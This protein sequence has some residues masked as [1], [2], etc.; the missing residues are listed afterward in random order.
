MKKVEYQGRKKRSTTNA[1]YLVD[2]QGLPLAMSEP[3]GGKH[4]DL[5]E[6]SDR[7]DEI[8]EQLSASG[9]AA[10][11][12]FSNLDAGFDGDNLRI[13]P[14]SHGIISNVCPNIRNG[15]DSSEIFV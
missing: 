11:G 12:L 15:A 8:A 6:I 3:Q 13:A 5:F 14:D 1:L 10:D 9:I 4:T 2:R 7:I